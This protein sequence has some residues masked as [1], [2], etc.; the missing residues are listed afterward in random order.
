MGLGSVFGV[1][2]EGAVCGSLVFCANEAVVWGR[3]R[4]NAGAPPVDGG[5]GRE[6]LAVHGLTVPVAAPPKEGPPP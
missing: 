1:D 5:T 4:G 2:D 3:G 6:A